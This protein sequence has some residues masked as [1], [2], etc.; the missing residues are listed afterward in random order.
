MEEE[1]IS[2]KIGGLEYKLQCP[3]EEQ[4]HLLE[5]A[6][7]LDKKIKSTKKNRQQFLLLLPK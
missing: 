4:A 1:I 2:I 3:I 5:A 6:E 7:K